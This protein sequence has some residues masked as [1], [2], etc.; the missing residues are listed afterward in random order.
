MTVQLEDYNQRKTDKKVNIALIDDELEDLAV[1]TN[2]LIDTI[3]DLKA[4]KRRT[5]NELKQAVANMSHDLRTPLT[6]IL[7]YIQ[8]AESDDVTDEEKREYLSIAKKRAKRLETLLNDFFEL[9]VIESMDYQLKSE[10]IN[11][12]NLTVDILMSFFDRFKD[13]NIGIIK[14]IHDV[15]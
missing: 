5:E 12:K 6:S 15:K 7:G 13:K 1:E 11:I 2:R 8:M 4:S 3:L 9:S 14:E 10:R